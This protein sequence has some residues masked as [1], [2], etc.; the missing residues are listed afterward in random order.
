MVVHPLLES[1]LTHS[2][3]DLVVV[4]VVVVVVAFVVVAVIVVVTIVVGLVVASAGNSG[5]V[6]DVGSQAF[7]VEWAR[8]VAWAVT[9][10]VRQGSFA[11]DLVVV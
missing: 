2:Y 9:G 4:V 6:Y 10:S 8:L 5:C 11:G 3:V 1:G 7:A